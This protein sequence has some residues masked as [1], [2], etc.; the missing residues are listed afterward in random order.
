MKIDPYLWLMI[1]PNILAM[2][3]LDVILVILGSFFILLGLVKEISIKNLLTIS[4]EGRLE[5]IIIVL[6]GLFMLLFSM[7]RVSIFTYK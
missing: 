6:F 3:I 4:V 1:I 5:K 7:V 2:V